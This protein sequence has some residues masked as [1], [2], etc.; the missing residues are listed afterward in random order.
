VLSDHEQR[1]LA[2]LERCCAM[3]A[4]EPDKPSR[5]VGRP[6]RPGSTA[7]LVLGAVSFALLVAGVAVAGLAVATAT[8][9]GWLFSRVW[10][11]R[12]DGGGIAAALSLGVGWGQSGPRPRLG[13]SIRQHLRWL[14]EA[15]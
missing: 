9:I 3:E 1:V 5:R 8:A 6:G 13:E 11:H 2:E 12:A 15:Q 4:L 7:V 10:S 14:S